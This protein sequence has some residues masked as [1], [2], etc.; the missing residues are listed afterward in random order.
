M[1]D[2]YD[3][4]KLLDFFLKKV[5]QLK[6]V[7]LMSSLFLLLLFLIGLNNSVKNTKLI[8]KPMMNT[9]I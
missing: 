8:K 9:T 7:S 6:R 4:K 2:K 5:E 3:I 1:V